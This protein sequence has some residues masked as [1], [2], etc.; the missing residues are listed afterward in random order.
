VQ[1]AVGDGQVWFLGYEP[2]LQ[3]DD[4]ANHYGVVGRIDPNTLK[5]VGVTELPD[6]GVL[7]NLRL[8]VADGSAWVFHSSAGTITRITG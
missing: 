3:S 6:V 5:V 2:G 4:P 1:V 7:D 8:F